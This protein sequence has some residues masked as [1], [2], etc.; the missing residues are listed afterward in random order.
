MRGTVAKRLRR[1][2]KLA[3][4]AGFDRMKVRTVNVEVGFDKKE[5]RPIF[6][7][8]STVFWPFM[9][10]RRQLKFLKRD[11]RVTGVRYMGD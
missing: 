8:R 1:E 5:D 2:A 3:A 4:F 10:F 9:S 6:E 7:Q 11:R